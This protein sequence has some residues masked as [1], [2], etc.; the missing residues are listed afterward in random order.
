MTIAKVDCTAD[1]ELCQSYNI[2]GYP[3][4]NLY[5][6]GFLYTSYNQGRSLSNLVSFVQSQIATSNQE[7]EALD[8]GAENSD[9]QPEPPAEESDPLALTMK[10]TEDTYKDIMGKKSHLIYFH[11]SGPQFSNM[12]LLIFEQVQNRLRFLKY[13]VTVAVIDCSETSIVCTELGINHYPSIMYFKSLKD[14]NQYFGMIDVEKI[15]E[16]VINGNKNDENKEE[17]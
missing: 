13:D 4:L 12:D 5:K 6:D 15:V 7:G 9:K 16:W 8:E 1:P 14:F 3:S 11:D 2:N 10:L 17:L